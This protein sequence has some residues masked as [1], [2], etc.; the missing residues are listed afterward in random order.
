MEVRYETRM[1]ASVGVLNIAKRRATA[2]P[3]IW[4]QFPVESTEISSP[5][6]PD[7]LDW[8]HLAPCSV[9]TGGVNAG[10]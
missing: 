1:T 9:V 2:M 10:V 3:A 6:L 8:A 7:R 5:K 4:V